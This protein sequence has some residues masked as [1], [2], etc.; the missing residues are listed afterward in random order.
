MDNWRSEKIVK[1]VITNYGG[2]VVGT[3]VK[4]STPTPVYAGSN[5]T[6][7]SSG[8]PSTFY[9]FISHIQ[10]FTVFVL[11]SFCFFRPPACL[12]ACLSEVLPV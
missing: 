4:C 11:T 12:P 9:I 10:V 6:D 3:V 2:S 8:C 5:H 7:G 1:F